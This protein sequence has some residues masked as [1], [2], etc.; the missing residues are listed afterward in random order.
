[1]PVSF[2]D[3]ILWVG[4][5]YFFEFFMHGDFNNRI[6]QS[7]NAYDQPKL[8]EY[9]YGAWLYPLYLID[10]A[11][12]PKPFDYTR[13]LIK[14]G[15]YE[16]DEYYNDTYT[17]YKNN[18]NVIKFDNRMDGFPEEWVAK[19]GLGSLKPI[20]LIYHARILNIFLLARAVIFAYFLALQYGGTVFSIVFS[21]FYGF[22]PLII[23]T[24]LKAHSEALFI[25]TINTAILFMNLYF[26]KGR[27]VLYLL[28]FSL[29][30]SLCMSTKL[31]GAFLFVIFFVSN[32]LIFII[33][34][35]KRVTYMIHGVIPV[36]IG[37]IIFVS[38]NPYTYSDPFKN[39]QNMFD[40]RNKTVISQA[41]GFP[42]TSIQRGQGIKKIF[43]NF[44]FS[45]QTQYF[46]GIQVYEQLGSLR[47]YGVYLFVLFSFGFVYTLKLAL[48]KN[49][50]AIVILCTFITIL[51]FM[52][53]YLIL[54]WVRYYAFLPLFFVLFQ[55]LGLFF[56]IQYVYKYSKFLAP[57]A[58]NRAH[59][60]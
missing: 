30:S 45:E 12:N 13:F 23:D 28:L 16:I 40:S 50:T 49:E 11:K 6:W 19:Y 34:K 20:N 14:N 53:Y 22:N 3:E 60:K 54:D 59:K 21:T 46:N 9:A 38:L 41:R 43:E 58:I 24:G 44:Y 18:F 52:N 33:S 42:E 27:K 37:L 26:T 47:N 5:S 31:N 36:I 1:M 25:F 57:R 17:T 10:K 8:A 56:V 4:R 7:G 15:F 48:K 51:A 29:F 39:S 35:E 55:S 32:I 2:W